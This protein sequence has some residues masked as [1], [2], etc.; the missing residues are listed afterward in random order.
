MKKN[1]FISG[2]IISTLSIV[3]VKIM[4]MLYVIPFYSIVGSKGGALYSYAYQLYLLFLGI[5]SAG[6]PNA[7]SKVIS[8]YNATG[9]LE[10]KTRAYHV[11]KRIILYISLV[12]FIL[13]FI[14]AEELAT[15][16]L[17]KITGGNTPE[18]A[19]FVIRCVSFAVLII[20]HL[21]VAKGYLQGHRAFEETSIANLLEQVVRIFI[22]LA[23][24]FLTYKVF[25]GSLTLAV[26]IAV[27]GAFFGGL[28]A[29]L[30]LKRKIKKYSNELDLNKNIAKDNVSNK[31]ITKKIIGYAVPFVII[32][33]VVDIYSVTDS[34]LILNTLT[35][36]GYVAEDVEFIASCISTWGS[37]ICMIVNAI[38][39]GMTASLIPSIVEAYSTHNID[40]LNKRINEALQMVVYISLPL[41][42]GISILSTPIWTIFYNTNPYGGSILKVAIFGAMLGNIAMILSC[43]LQGM[44]KFKYVY[45]LNIIGSLI[46]AILD[47]PLMIL[48]NK[49]GLPAY[50]GAS[51]ASIIGYSISI[52]LGLNYINHEKNINYKESLIT[53]LKSLIPA[54]TMTLVLLIINKFLPL[55]VYKKI[56][57]FIIII[58]DTIIG[59]IIYIYLSF[60]LKL[61]EKVFG[62]EYLNKIL[63][64]L[65]F[66]KLKIN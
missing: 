38:A 56:D 44:N 46:N 16:Y 29:Y 42:I 24:S 21:S 8:E 35:S 15:L 48:F 39:M 49:L 27:S 54:I 52:I 60:K 45:L 34:V 30:Y 55:D 9:K 28:V 58:I 4:G 14:F 11:G 53:I 18:D 20:P 65:T 41:A 36:L 26:G 6:I 40:N 2:T 32:S 22:I 7:I 1:S 25:N 62:K 33:I 5:S 50:Y 47:V 63:K 57:S 13:L 12:A 23:G 17:G 37:K 51:T 10:A 31:E 19:A 3:L 59:G 61:P 66:G 64:K 43:T